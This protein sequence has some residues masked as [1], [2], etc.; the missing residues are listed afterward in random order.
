MGRGDSSGFSVNMGVE[1]VHT[2]ESNGG[3][4]WT[5]DGKYHREDGPALIHKDGTQ[6]WCA[7][8]LLHRIDGPAM[9][10]STGTR[11]WCIN[12]QM[13]RMD[14]PAITRTDGTREWWIKGE[15]ITE[16][17]EK[18]MKD[19]DVPWPFDEETQVEF[20]LTLL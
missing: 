19:K 16:Q 1:P 10:W 20:L 5:V 13:H 14:G 6:V 15:N 3:Q 2:I 9:I 7:N 17:V 11:V 18:W 4:Y 12:D 8:G